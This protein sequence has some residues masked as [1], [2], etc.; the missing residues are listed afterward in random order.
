MWSLAP[1]GT[2]HT[3]CGAQMYMQAEHPY[4]RIKLL[5][6]VNREFKALLLQRTQVSVPMRL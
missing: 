5:N 4:T 1:V 6:R 2:A 3:E